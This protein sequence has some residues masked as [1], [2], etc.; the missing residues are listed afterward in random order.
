MIK[1]IKNRS[2][3]IMKPTFSPDKHYI[4]DTGLVIVLVLLLT[5]YWT[6]KSLF[7]LLAIGVLVVAMT[8][9]VILKPLAIVWHYLSTVIGN[10]MNRI[11]L[12]VIFGVLLIPVGVFRRCLGFDPMMRKKWKNG[13]H[14]VFSVRNHTYTSD[15]L[16]TPY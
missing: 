7:I 15:D 14:S 2:L 11:V 6:Q 13:V 12:A 4:K 1:L 10:V 5:A 9:P 16:N 8:I 3:E